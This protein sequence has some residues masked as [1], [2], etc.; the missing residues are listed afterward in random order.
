MIKTIR[1]KKNVFLGVVKIMDNVQ[2]VYV[3]VKRDIV[4]LVHNSV[5]LL[6][7][8]NQ[9]MVNVLKLDVEKELENVQMVNAVVK[10]DIV[11]LIHNSVHL[12]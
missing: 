7:D 1:K 3:V 6:K 12:L 10:R 8:V 9:P 2:M 11:V 5:H 4:A